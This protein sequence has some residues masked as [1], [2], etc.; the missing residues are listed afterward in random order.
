MLHALPGRT[1]IAL[2]VSLLLAALAPV[3]PAQAETVLISTNFNALPVGFVYQDDVF[4]TAQPNYASGSHSATAGYEGG[5]LRVF[6]GGVDANA[7]G[8]MSGAWVYTLGL[9]AP[10]TGVQL[11]FRY[12]L[13]QTATYEYDEYSQ[14]L[15]KVDGF[16]YG[17]GSKPYVDQIGGDGSSSQGNSS[18][19]VPHTD[20]QLVNLYIGPLNAGIHT[21]SIGAYNNRKDATDE[22]TTLT[23]DDF[24]ISSDNAAP[25]DSSAAVLVDR[26]SQSQFKGFIQGVAQFHDRCSASGLGCSTEGDTSNFMGA[27]A[28]VE[29]R[30]QS[31]GYITVRHAFNYNGNTGTNLWATKV[32]TVTPKEMYIVSAHLD[33]R[34]GG[35]GF[36]DDGSGVGLVLEVARVLAAADVTTDKSVRFCFWDKEESGLNGAYGYVQDRKSLQGTTEEP[37][38]LGVIQHDMVLYD[39]GAGTRTTGQSPY[40]D[41]DVE[42]RS[43]TTQAGASR[44]LAYKWRFLNGDYATDYPATAYDYSTNTDD[45]PF[46]GSVASISVRENRRSLTTGANAEWIN[47]YY[48]TTGDVEASYSEADFR[49]GFNAVQTTLGVVATL[50]GAHAPHV[51]VA[52]VALAG[53]VTT[54]ED[55]PTS[56]ALAATDAEGDP[57]TYAVLTPPSHGALS[58]TAPNL[59]YT[60]AANYN[61]ADAFTFRAHDGSL[62]SA[63]AT[64][65]I[66]VTPVNDA[67]LALPQSVAVDEDTTLALTLAGSDVDGGGLMY[68]IATA[69]VHGSLS[70]AAPNV[71][72]RPAPDY[73]GADSFT[74]VAGDDGL[75]SAPA[76]VNIMVRAVNDAPVAWPGS[77]VAQTDVPVGVTLKATDVDCVSG[78]CGNLTYSVVMPP[79]PG[80]LSGVTPNLTYASA[81]GFSGLDG[82]TFS[83]SDGSL[84]SSP[85]AV[86]ILVSS[87]AALTAPFTEDFEGGNGWQINPFGTDSAMRGIW[88]QATPGATDADGPKQLATTPSGVAALVTGPFGGNAFDDDID[89][90]VTSVLSPPIQLSAGQTFILSLKYVFAHGSNSSS[91]DYLRVKVLGSSPLTVLEVYGSNDDL[92]AAWTPFQV[93]LAP[94]AGQTIQV[95][96]EAADLG[97][98]SLVEAALDDVAVLPRPTGSSVLA[99]SFDAGADGFVYQDDAFRG[100]SQSLYA[101]GAYAPL[102]GVTSGA[103]RVTLGGLDAT[104]IN[105]MAGG[106]QKSFTLANAG[107][108]EVSF[109][110]QLTQSSEYEPDEI[111]QAL[112]TIDGALYGAPPNEFVAQLEGNGN[113]GAVETTGWRLYSR[114]IGPLAAGQHTLMLGGWNN[115]KSYPD[116]TTEVL[117]DEVQVVTR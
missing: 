11:T 79:A 71:A 72:Y 45:T 47:P 108:V 106:W 112:L 65:S 31:M 3:Q 14:V 39:H 12:K 28:Y 114:T 90:G 51:N 88:R 70:G 74:F 2:V 5:G 42:W 23:V 52:P 117:V 19:F 21:F 115:R 95:L 96:I 38:W 15:V 37:T 26:A 20:W 9:D 76:T 13:E 83:A 7:I 17:R 18:S 49:L 48:H 6:V 22:S 101:D 102:V 40:A 57:L 53:Y 99:A 89:D 75:A 107:N 81:S 36:D 4:D 63:P 67:P 25:V 33:A 8:E 43:G 55:T 110:F 116:E 61:G 80:S 113:G 1:V 64:V 98:P 29:Q 73:N 97:G 69:P 35:D 100:V 77:V 59:T 109:W 94:F 92:D 50:A 93:S 84:A 41:L 44:A 30:L 56:I 66:T 46:H 111:S 91:E 62:N 10:I 32:G 104:L 54:A 68:T 85:A 16:R 60:P 34:S 86:S 82:F 87:G 103:L 27:L 105:G 24:A 58:G 78:S